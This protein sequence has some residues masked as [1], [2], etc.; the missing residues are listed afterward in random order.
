MKKDTVM[1]LMMMRIKYL[2]KM[3]WRDNLM[4]QKP[5]TF[6]EHFKE[7]KHLKPREKLDAFSR[8]DNKEKDDRR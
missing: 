6:S 2:L 4:F 7:Q 8:L 5:I 1:T 3:T